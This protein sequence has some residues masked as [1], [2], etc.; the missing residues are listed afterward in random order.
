MTLQDRYHI[1]PSALAGGSLTLCELCGKTNAVLEA[2]IEGTSIK[3][4][5][6]CKKFGRVVS[7]IKENVLPVVQKKHVED[8]PVEL[9]VGDYGL[10]I[11]TAR[12]RLGKTQDELAQLLNEKV[13]LLRKIETG[14]FEPPL[15]T[16]KKMERV[17]KIQLVEKAE[18]SKVEL[19]HE[20]NKSEGF[21]IGDLI[22]LKE[23]KNA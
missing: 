17:L 6:S 9:I 7:R 5:A 12:E 8:I 1:R 11:K 10:K 19:P 4:C 23:K 18:S 13:S 21:T 14:Q 20:N 16:V 15:D 22:K 3:V 2:I